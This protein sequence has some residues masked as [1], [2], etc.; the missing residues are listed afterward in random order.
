M[1]VSTATPT[2]S[3]F[4]RGIP[5]AEASEIQPGHKRVF[6]AGEKEI[7]VFNLEGAFYAL[8]N[9]CPHGG[10]R[11]ENGMVEGDSVVCPGHNWKFNIRTGECETLD[12]EPTGCYELAMEDG[13]LM[14]IL[15][16]AD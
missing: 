15:N 11:F 8:D 4:T 14:L 1:N 3:L 5:L 10:F 6:L 13:M 9:K 12:F 2:P 7:I 16:E